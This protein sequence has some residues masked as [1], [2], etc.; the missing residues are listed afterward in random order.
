MSTTPTTLSNHFRIIDWI[1][2][3]FLSK[4][5]GKPSIL[6]HLLFAFANKWVINFYLLVAPKNLSDR[7]H[8]GLNDNNNAAIV[9]IAR[10][11]NAPPL[12]PV[13]PYSTRQ[14]P[15]GALLQRQGSD[16]SVCGNSRHVK[17]ATSHLAKGGSRVVTAKHGSTR[18][19]ATP[20]NAARLR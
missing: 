19:S 4:I 20:E 11:N 1:Y 14:N 17:P 7:P 12:R 15:A 9:N 6:S 13:A 18:V 10:Q 8:N 3:V 16:S 2:I 5:I